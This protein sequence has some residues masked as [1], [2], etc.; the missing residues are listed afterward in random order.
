[1]EG[2]RNAYEILVGKGRDPLG[3]PTCRWEEHITMD[4]SEIW[5]EVV[6]WTGTSG[7]LL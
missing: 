1:M 7:G 5:W 3:R 4:L 6:D 2:I